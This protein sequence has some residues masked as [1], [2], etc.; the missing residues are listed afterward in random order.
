MSETGLYDG[1]LMNILQS[2]QKN[3]ENDSSYSSALCLFYDSIFSFMRR[4]TD[5]FTSPEQGK[6]MVLE[7]FAKN[8]ALFNEDKERQLLIKKKQEEEK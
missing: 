6:Q 4:K 1:V 7:A 8:E 5:F 3:Q 2:A